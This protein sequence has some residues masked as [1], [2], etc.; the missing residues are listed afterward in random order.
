MQPDLRSMMNR[1]MHIKSR[2]KFQA[3]LFPLV[4]ESSH[5]WKIKKKAQSNEL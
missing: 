4:L 2:K 5:S 3:V 1:F